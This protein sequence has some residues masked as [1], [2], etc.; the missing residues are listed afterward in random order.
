MSAPLTPE[1]R[2][3][4]VLHLVPGLG[5]RLTAALLDRFGSA[6]AVLGASSAELCD[7]PHIGPKLAGDIREALR[8]ADVDGELERMERHG[9]RLLALGTP[10]YP[11][12]LSTIPDPSHLLYIRGTFEARDAKAV[13]VVGSR[14]CTAYGRRVTERLAG[15]LARAGY[16]IV[17]GL[18]LGTSLEMNRSRRR[19]MTPR[20]RTLFIRGFPCRSVP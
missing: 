11:E 7:V 10:E 18:P 19:W 4:L 16:T 6:E 12:S 5:P 1:V 9:V 14:R 3:L 17:S 8:G 20:V 15:G 13:A 2:A